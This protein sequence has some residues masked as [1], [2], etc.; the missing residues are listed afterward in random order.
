MDTSQS[1]S[2]RSTRLS[3]RIYGRGTRTNSTTLR[4]DRANAAKAKRRLV[5]SIVVL[6]AGA[7]SLGGSASN[8]LAQADGPI[9]RCQEIEAKDDPSLGSTELT[10]LYRLLARINGEALPCQ[11]DDPYPRALDELLENASDRKSDDYSAGKPIIC[12]PRGVNSF[13]KNAWKQATNRYQWTR[14]ALDAL[15]KQLELAR[16]TSTFDGKLPKMMVR[17]IGFADPSSDD[18]SASKNMELSLKRAEAIRDALKRRLSNSL[19]HYEFVTEGRG[20]Y[21]LRPTDPESDGNGLLADKK[22]GE[23]DDNSCTALEERTSEKTSVNQKYFTEEEQDLLPAENAVALIEADKNLY[24]ASQRR[25]EIEVTNPT[26]THVGHRLTKI[27]SLDSQ[28]TD[29]R[30]RLFPEGTLPA[31]TFSHA[32]LFAR[33]NVPDSC[34]PKQESIKIGPDVDIKLLR[35]ISSGWLRQTV[36]PLDSNSEEQASSRLDANDGGLSLKLDIYPVWK[37]GRSKPEKGLRVEVFLARL[38]RFAGNTAKVGPF[39]RGIGV[40][41]YWAVHQRFVDLMTRVQEDE[42]VIGC[43]KSLTNDLSDL[44][45]LRANVVARLPKDLNGI[46]LHAHRLDQTFRFFDLSAGM[47]LLYR[48]TQADALGK[49]IHPSGSAELQLRADPI[50]PCGRVPMPRVTGINSNASPLADPRDVMISDPFIAL[51]ESGY[52]LSAQDS[53]CAG[54][55]PQPAKSAPKCPAG[56]GSDED[57]CTQNFMPLQSYASIERFLQQ[58][59]IRIFAPKSEIRPGALYRQSPNNAEDFCDEEDPTKH[60]TFGWWAKA[61]Q[62]S[63]AILVVSASSRETLDSWRSARTFGADPEQGDP[64]LPCVQSLRCGYLIGNMSVSPTVG[65]TMGS[66][67]Q[68]VILGTRFVHLLPV[69]IANSCFEI[70]RRPNPVNQGRW[71]SNAK[72]SKPVDFEIGGAPREEPVRTG[73]M[74]VDRRDC[75]LLGLY[76]TQGSYLTWSR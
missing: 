45:S 48:P 47:T 19:K 17:I 8:S 12:F 63:S 69:E 58:G 28:D 4:F 2:T 9:K 56:D 68:R 67:A 60:C 42:V 52:K 61:P 1:R 26:V 43:L 73:S 70:E 23:R 54:E 30:L 65:I 24:I 34:A 16:K 20:P 18:T 27:A 44:K 38:D 75:R 37:S 39:R 35:P 40:P 11:P 25:V 74:L 49:W 57:S 31:R 50:D 76:L 66:Q 7:L 51:M 36:D 14:D 22:T 10:P 59:P 6:V 41:G 72:L 71:Q 5:Y 55:T 15:A 21:H 3:L 62:Q 64:L 46:L 53:G 29:V 33:G 32:L 13:G